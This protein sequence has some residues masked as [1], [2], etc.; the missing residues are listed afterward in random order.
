MG[1]NSAHHQAVD[2]VAEPL[3]VTARSPDG[4]VEGME[5]RPEA[6]QSLPFLLAVQFHPERMADHHPEHAAIFRAFIR[7]CAPNRKRKL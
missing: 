4:V 7:A 5:L 2:R 1:V 6:R 3:R